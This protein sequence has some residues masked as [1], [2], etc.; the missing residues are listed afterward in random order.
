MRRKDFFLIFE[1]DENMERLILLML[2]IYLKFLYQKNSKWNECFKFI[3][4]IL[5]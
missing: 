1:Y 4:K 3:L 2:Y 5:N